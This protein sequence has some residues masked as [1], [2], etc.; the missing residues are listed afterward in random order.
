MH[1]LKFTENNKSTATLSF[2]LASLQKWT[3]LTPSVVDITGLHAPERR[4]IITTRISPCRR[5]AS[6][7]PA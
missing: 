1:A 5:W 6:G 2:D 7:G 3:P 4:S